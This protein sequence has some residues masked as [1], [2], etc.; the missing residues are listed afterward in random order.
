MGMWIPLSEG[1][2]APAFF[3]GYDDFFWERQTPEGRECWTVLNG[4]RMSTT[5]AEASCFLLALGIERP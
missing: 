1:G 5:R 4:P 2:D 3:Q